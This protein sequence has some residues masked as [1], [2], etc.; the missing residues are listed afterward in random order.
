M[1]NLSDFTLVAL[2]RVLEERGYSSTEMKA[3]LIRRLMEADPNGKW[4]RGG[5]AS[6]GESDDRCNNAGAS[7]VGESTVWQDP[8]VLRREIELCRKEK[9]LAERELELTRRELELLRQSQV[10]DNAIDGEIRQRDVDGDSDTRTRC[11]HARVNVTAITD[12][13]SHFDGKSATYDIWE[14]QVRLLRATYRLEDDAA[15]L[16]IGMLL[17]GK[18]LEWLHSKPEYIG[19]PFDV[20]LNELRSTFQHRQ[21]R[22]TMRKR[23][24]E[25]TWKKDETFHEY[26]HE[27][28]IMG[29]RVPIDDDEMLEYIID[30]IPDE[31]L[32]NQARVQGF[33]T[34]DTLLKAF[35][36][37]TF[38][39]RN[40]SNTTKHGYN[41]NKN[42]SWNKE[43]KK[44][45]KTDNKKNATNIVIRC[46]NCGIRDHTGINCPTKEQGVKCFGCNERGHIISKCPKKVEATKKSY[47]MTRSLSKKYIKDVII[48]EQHIKALVDSGSDLTLMCADEYVKL[49]LP[50]FQPGGMRFR[51][52]GSDD[53]MTLGEFRTDIVVDGHS[54]P[55][56]IVT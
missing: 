3:E 12:L 25:R 44:D 21:T 9:E 31:A 34:V 11:A 38:R 16:V 52:I 13:L 30:G 15:R 51:G 4:L 27:K 19:M 32:R 26:Y 40:T 53:N 56:P 10:R 5:D 20:L 28:I 55:I 45:G 22:V 23:F 8:D 17:K 7:R 33:E 43:E 1:K 39:E 46:H 14:K 50:G 48:H 18:A 47:A 36:K 54:Y 42:N 24:E 6:S 41:N 35:E 37:V 49:G 2:K 29:N